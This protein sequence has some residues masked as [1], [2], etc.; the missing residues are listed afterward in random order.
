ML[1]IAD[2]SSS[3][4]GLAGAPSPI[5]VRR[6]IPPR[7]G[8]TGPA[9][10]NRADGRFAR[11]PPSVTPDRLVDPPGRAGRDVDI[12]SAP[13][14]SPH[15]LLSLQLQNAHVGVDHDP[16]RLESA[17]NGQGLRLAGAQDD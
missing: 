1:L 12:V 15:P 11:K 10:R 17:A 7:C 14:Q 6:E 8:R 9:P 3:S 13:L 2:L 4:T 16:L 5:T